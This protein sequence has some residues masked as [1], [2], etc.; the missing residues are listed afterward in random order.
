[1][2]GHTV[3]AVP[4]PPLEEAVRAR[5]RHYDPSFVSADSGFGHAH[6][7][8]L[9]PWIAQPA[10]Q[11]LARVG[12]IVAG[13]APARIEFTEVEI[14]ATGL[15]HLKPEPDQLFRTL[16]REL[17]AAFP[18]HPPYAAAYPEAS[19]HLPLDDLAGGVSLAA[20]RR[21]LGAL[22]PISFTADRVDLQWWAEHDCRLLHSWPLD[23]PR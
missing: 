16:T 12:T 9:A 11:D 6:I 14:F 2:S 19:P 21:R 20:V 18:D 1:V 8:L 5:T 10:P 22:L 4:V 13:L 15:I 3:L 7:T 23:G 17:S